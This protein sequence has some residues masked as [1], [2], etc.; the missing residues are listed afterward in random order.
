[1]IHV[2][3][4]D[5]SLLKC[6]SVKSRAAGPTCITSRTHVKLF[7]ADCFVVVPPPRK[8][9]LPFVLNVQ[10]CDATGDAMKYYSWVHKKSITSYIFAFEIIDEG[11][12]YYAVAAG[13]GIIAGEVPIAG[14]CG[15]AL[16]K[17]FYFLIDNLY[18]N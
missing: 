8:D 16:V 14:V 11:F 6:R 4:T 13:R 10:E 18:G 7:N 2:V 12:V 17:V 15:A 5:F 9:A 3:I 1:M